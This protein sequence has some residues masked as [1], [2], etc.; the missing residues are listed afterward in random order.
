MQNLVVKEEVAEMRN[1]IFFFHTVGTY[2]LLPGLFVLY[3]H[4]VA[5]LHDRQLLILDILYMYNCDN[6]CTL[7]REEL[8]KPNSKGRGTDTTKT[9]L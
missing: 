4:I 6:Q 3:P 1:M 9:V 7:A 8:S 5:C 2:T